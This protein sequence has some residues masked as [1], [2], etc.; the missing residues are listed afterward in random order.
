LARTLWLLG[1]PDQALQIARQTVRGLGA[2]EPVTACISLIWAASIFLWTGDLTSADD[3]IDRL[4]QHAERHS[5]TPYRAVGHGLK[6]EALIQRE[7]IE[8]GLDL[9]CG[10]LAVLDAEG[11]QL[12]A[13]E[14]KSSLARG[15][16]MMDRD[17]EALLIVD[18]AIAHVIRHGDLSMPELQR[19]RGE[20]L[21]KTGDEVGAE[22]AF[23][24]A[25]ELADQQSALSWRLRASSSLARLQSRQ[26]RRE[27]ARRELAE[28]YA[29]FNE[30]FNT[31]D[32][33]AA[34][35]LLKRL[36]EQHAGDPPMGPRARAGNR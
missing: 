16:A 18:R 30:G 11:Y 35:H 32:L 28:T 7:E 26:G 25:K 13:T 2:A 6:G 3:C 5:L 1:Y 10:S 29:R 33:K 4:I 36:A 17:G 12:Y 14:F 27:K 21:A 23:H 24:H 19:V 34:E 15:L 9:L 20:L 8:T 22:Q 31:A